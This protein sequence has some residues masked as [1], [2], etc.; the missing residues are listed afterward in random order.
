M[1]G[2][3]SHRGLPFLTRASNLLLV[4]PDAR[5]AIRNRF[6]LLWSCAPDTDSGFASHRGLSFLNRAS[7][8]LLVIPDAPSAIRNRFGPLGS[9][10]PDTDS[11]G[12]LR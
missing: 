2:F 1:S 10:A 7:N 6:G 11:G 12:D 5:S 8:L 9:S 4:I 3:D